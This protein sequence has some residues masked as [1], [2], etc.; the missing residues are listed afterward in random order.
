MTHSYYVH[1]RAK[2]KKEK[3]G[4]IYNFFMRFSTRA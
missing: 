1:L 3:L 4:E 2:K